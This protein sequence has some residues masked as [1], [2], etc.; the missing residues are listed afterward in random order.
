MYAD[1]VSMLWEQTKGRKDIQRLE[2][3]LT[4]LRHQL[5]VER[6][7][8]KDKATQLGELK[9]VSS[10]MYFYATRTYKSL[11]TCFALPFLAFPCLRLTP[12]S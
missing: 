1:A 4:T 2:A 8:L 12:T 11:S 6:A 9:T 5:G 3:E 10:C 7:I